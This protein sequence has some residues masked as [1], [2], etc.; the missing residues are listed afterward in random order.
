[1]PFCSLNSALR[2]A[3]NLLLSI[4]GVKVPTYEFLIDSMRLFQCANMKHTETF[5]FLHADKTLVVLCRLLLLL[6]FLALSL[7]AMVLQSNDIKT[8]KAGSPLEM[9]NWNSNVKNF[10]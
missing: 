9:R 7:L 5:V 8:I 6:L 10:L 2:S 1:M 3:Y 4:R